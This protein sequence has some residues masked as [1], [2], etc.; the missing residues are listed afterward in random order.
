MRLTIRPLLTGVLLAIWCAALSGLALPLAPQPLLLTHLISS[1]GGL[2]PLLAYLARH[3][4]LRR[5]QRPATT[6]SG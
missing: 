5:H 2:V 1:L 4:W 6:R 3:W